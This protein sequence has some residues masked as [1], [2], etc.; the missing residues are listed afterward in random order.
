[1]LKVLLRGESEKAITKKLFIR[2]HTVHSR[3][4]LLAKYVPGDSVRARAL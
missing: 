4:A 2:Q 1:V 3:P